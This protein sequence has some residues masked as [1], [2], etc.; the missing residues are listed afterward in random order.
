MCI[1]KAL[2]WHLINIEFSS[3]IILKSIFCLWV[4]FIKFLLFFISDSRLVVAKF[5]LGV[6][7][8]EKWAVVD[9]F[10]LNLL[11]VPAIAR[12]A[13]ISILDEFLVEVIWVVFEHDNFFEFPFFFLSS[14]FLNGT[15]SVVSRSQHL[16]IGHFSETFKPR[17]GCFC[18]LGHFF[19][20]FQLDALINKWAFVGLYQILVKTCRLILII[21]RSALSFGYSVC[22]NLRIVVGFF[23]GYQIILLHA[24]FFIF[25][26]IE[27]A[28][29]EFIQFLHFLY[30]IKKES[31]LTWARL[32]SE[33]IFNSFR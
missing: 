16:L 32:K 21:S 19:N 1:I 27:I 10:H 28:L 29:L 5:L 9:G 20:G 8:I 22:E 12:N 14:L 13:T 30:E 24:I 11:I 23:L 6:R 31:E 3:Q 26:L 17:I 33:F 18:G 7:I 25:T 15:R 2:H 4:A